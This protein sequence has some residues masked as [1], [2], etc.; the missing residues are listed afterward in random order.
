MYADLALC[1]ASL[2][3]ALVCLIASQVTRSARAGAW[4]PVASTGSV[5]HVTAWGLSACRDIA[6]R[7][8]GVRRSLPPRINYSAC[9]SSSC[10]EPSG[11]DNA[12]SLSP[13]FASWCLRTPCLQEVRDAIGGGLASTCLP[14]AAPCQAT[15]CSAS[16]A[17]EH[18]SCIDE[19]LPTT[20]VLGGGRS[21]M[22]W[23]T[24]SCSL[25]V[26]RGEWQRT[27]SALPRV[28]TYPA[29]CEYSN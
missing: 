18:T 15:T 20:R 27:R 1:I 2:P 10:S 19:D 5:E 25:I 7:S 3:W 4:L 14:G 9:Q 24:R 16:V 22:L 29:D 28:L 26:V 13:C 21:T 11:S 8:E 6:R 23:S 17:L 12:G